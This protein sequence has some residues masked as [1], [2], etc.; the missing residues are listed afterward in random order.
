MSIIDRNARIHVIAISNGQRF[1]LQK[2]ETKRNGRGE[3]V[4]WP[5]WSNDPGNSKPL[6]YEIA[7]VF[8]RRMAEEHRSTVYFAQHAGDTAELFEQ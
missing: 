8:K 2:P 5:V 6:P 1:Y 7:V 4:L 3:L